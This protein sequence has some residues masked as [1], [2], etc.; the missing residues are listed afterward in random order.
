MP[1]FDDSQENNEIF[2]YALCEKSLLMLNYL[3][4]FNSAEKGS[5]KPIF[6]LLHIPKSK[7][8][9]T[10]IRMIVTQIYS[11]LC[12]ICDLEITILNKNFY[13]SQ[14]ELIRNIL[15]INRFHDRKH[16]EKESPF[17]FSVNQHGAGFENDKEINVNDISL[18]DGKIMSFSYKNPKF[19]LLLNDTTVKYSKEI[20]DMIIKSEFNNLKNKID[21]ECRIHFININQ[22]DTYENFLT[23][24]NEMVINRF[25]LFSEVSTNLAFINHSKIDQFFINLMSKDDYHDDLESLVFIISI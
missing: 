9:L 15:F 7:S 14:I 25:C 5:I 18:V 22:F 24:M 8:N 19:I 23:T 21:K 3:I 11:F 2:V 10:S 17:S 16:N 1:T 6:L 13:L 4:D 12:T 20:D